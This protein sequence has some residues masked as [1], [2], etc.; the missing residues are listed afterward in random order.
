[1]DVKLAI[2]GGSAVQLFSDVAAVTGVAKAAAAA[3]VPNF[4]MR[5]REIMDTPSELAL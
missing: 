2:D 5:R 4:K 3:A 1:M